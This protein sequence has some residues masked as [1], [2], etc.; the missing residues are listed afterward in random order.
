MYDL[1]LLLKE[2]KCGT[3]RSNNDF[4]RPI[5]SS[6]FHFHAVQELMYTFLDCYNISIIILKEHSHGLSVYLTYSWS[7]SFAAS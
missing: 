2:R 6:F 5:I 4:D 7:D 3:C 1:G